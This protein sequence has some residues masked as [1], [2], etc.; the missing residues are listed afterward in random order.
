MKKTINRIEDEILTIVEGDSITPVALN[1]TV[2]RKFRIAMDE[3]KPVIR[4]LIAQGHL[5]YSDNQ[6][7]TVI[8]KSFSKPVRISDHIML[9][10]PGVNFNA[11]K[12]DV[13]LEMS[14][15]A[16]F[17][18]GRH[19]ST[20]VAV[21]ALEHVLKNTLFLQYR[22]PSNLLDIGTGSGILAIAALHLGITTAVGI[23]TDPAARYEAAQNA[24]A[25]GVEKRFEI[26]DAP[27][28]GIRDKF[29]MVAANLRYPTLLRI[30]STI[31]DLLKPSGTVVLSGI[32]IEESGKILAA[33]ASR[34]YT[35]DWHATE[36]GWRSMVFC[37]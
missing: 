20:R 31:S 33:Y 35:C 37:R 26:L 34:G 19:P 25:N 10:P 12:E 15:G 8:E 4:N 5:A 13:L 21:R 16:A 29:D 9:K 36:N 23:D 7:R 32:K 1:K 22:N 14:Q 30:C 28:E 11:G 17:G 24:Q 27:L 18:D 6:G 2:S 3:V